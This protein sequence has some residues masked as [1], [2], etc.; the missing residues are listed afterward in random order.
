METKQ[1][2]VYKITN[3]VNGK[4]YIGITTQTLKNRWKAH[5]R[6]AENSNSR[7]ICRAIKKY[8]SDNFLIEPIKECG[9]I[10]EMRQEEINYIRLF[11]SMNIEKG[12]NLT[13]GGEGTFGFKP[14]K[15]QLE[16]HSKAM[17]GK[18]PGHKN[19]FYGKKH[20]I[21]TLEII[22]TKNKL[23]RERGAYKKADEAAK[24]LSKEQELLARKEYATKLFTITELANKY[25]VSKST[26]LRYLDGIT[27]KQTTNKLS[28]DVYKSI[29][30]MH[31]IEKKSAREI[32][33]ITNLAAHKIE[34]TIQTYRKENNILSQRG[35]RINHP[36]KNK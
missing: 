6:D 24:K 33:E 5:I 35:N 14:S 30:D 31:F 16:N 36:Y 20:S 3:K 17:K 1:F 27:G 12:Y 23:A 7:L 21:E 22:S 2:F 18:M 34:R 15:E 29:I 4:V 32:G 26:M 9:S 11:D 10:A 8:G 13:T 19:P 25:N 28:D